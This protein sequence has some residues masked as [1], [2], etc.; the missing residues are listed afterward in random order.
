MNLSKIEYALLKQLHLQPSELWRKPFYEIE[1]L[2]EHMKEDYE[3][4]KKRR[5]SEEDQ[6]KKYSAQ[7]GNMQK[8]MQQMNKNF[9]KSIGNFSMPK[10]PDAN[11]FKI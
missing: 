7:F 10:F 8:E 2:M 4:E 11:N 9:D 3:E 5:K 1:Y 6:H